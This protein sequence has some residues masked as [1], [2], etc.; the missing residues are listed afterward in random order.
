MPPETALQQLSR[1]LGNNPPVNVLVA[2]EPDPEAGPVL[3]RLA[4][5]RDLAQEFLQT[6]QD[7]IPRND[8]LTLRPYEPGYTPYPH[9]LV[10]IDLRQNQPLAAQIA[11]VAEVQQA[12]LFRE[13]DGIVDHLRFYGIVAAPTAQRRAVFFRN[14]SPKKELT[15]R[16]GF[17]ALFQQGHYNKVE[18]KIFLFDR[19]VD[20]FSW[21]GYLFIRSVPGFQ[22]MFRYFE[23]LRARA[24]ETVDTIRD[25]IPIGNL[26]EFRQACTG[27]V[28]LMSK[29]AI[30]AQKPYLPRVTIRDL[31]K[32]IDEF[33][34]DVRIERVGGREVLM[35]E[36][37][38]KKRWLLLK[39]LDDDFLGSVM[40]NEKYEVNSKST[41]RR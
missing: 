10:Y 7:A 23:E 3:Q 32:T 8:D 36:K 40:T 20:C 26:D 4:L 27:Q 6:A 30:I 5:H 41:L 29:L 35:F 33:G 9:E 11:S 2:S 22:R 12:E 14:Y 1:A 37:E 28:Q 16:A 34:L 39:L 21:D 18:S 24:D 15:R 19:N 38:P 17:A 31:K 25:H 13:D